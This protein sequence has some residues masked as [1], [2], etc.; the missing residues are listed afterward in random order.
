MRRISR[1]AIHSV[2]SPSRSGSS[3]GFTLIG[4]RTLLRSGW[5]WGAQLDYAF[6]A[7]G[8]EV[9]AEVEGLWAIA[10]DERLT[11]FLLV[12]AGA[13]TGAR[14]APVAG[15]ILSPRAGLS[16][17]LQ[18]PGSFGNDLRLEAA[19]C[20]RFLPT[21]TSAGFENGVSAQASVRL[22]LGVLRDVAFSARAELDAVWRPGTAVAATGA[23]GLEL[24]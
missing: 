1:T 13:R 22:R 9:N 23:L 12:F 6:V 24:D 7:P 8:H 2:R 3:V 19:Y 20:P 15:A 4:V 16:A 18:L 5:G 14:V 21:A 10:A 17:R 11:N